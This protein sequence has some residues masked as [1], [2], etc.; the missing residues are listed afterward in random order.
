MG[1]KKIVTTKDSSGE[2]KSTAVSVSKKRV[3]VGTLA[4]Q[5]TYNNTIVTLSDIKGKWSYRI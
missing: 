5:S 1:K 4:I 3:D 2:T